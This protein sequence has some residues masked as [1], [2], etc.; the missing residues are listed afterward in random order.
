MMSSVGKIK[1]YILSVIYNCYERKEKTGM[2][3][4]QLYPDAEHLLTVFAKDASMNTLRG[5]S[6]VYIYISYEEY[7][8]FVKFCIYNNLPVLYLRLSKYAEK[9]YDSQTMMRLYYLDV[10]EIILFEMFHGFGCGGTCINIRHLFKDEELFVDFAKCGRQFFA[11]DKCYQ[12]KSMESVM[13]FVRSV[14]DLN[15]MTKDLQKILNYGL[16]LRALSFNTDAVK[17]NIGGLS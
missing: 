12:D 3:E 10:S 11:M 2:H 9:I 4:I 8:E 16:Y 14:G 5:Q 7:L 17:F 1:N 15:G 6:R 13:P